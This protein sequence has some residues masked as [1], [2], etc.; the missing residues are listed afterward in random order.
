M[1]CLLNTCAEHSLITKNLVCGKIIKKNFN[2]IE[3]N[4]NKIDVLGF[5]DCVVNIGENQK[6]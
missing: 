4:S 2:L 1:L 6:L 5:I 3:A